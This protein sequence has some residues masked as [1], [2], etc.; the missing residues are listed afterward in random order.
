MTPQHADVDRVALYVARL[1]LEIKRGLRPPGHLQP[2]LGAGMLSVKWRR[3]RP[4][5]GGPYG[6]VTPADIGVPVVSAAGDRADASVPINL[7]GA[8]GWVALTVRLRR[9]KTRWR[10]TDLTMLLGGRGYVHTVRRERPVKDPLWPLHRR[11]GT[12]KKDR[13]LVA[14]VA[15][16]NRAD[17]GPWGPLLDQ[18]D[19]EIAQLQQRIDVLDRHERWDWAR[20]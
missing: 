17:A 15:V 14:M 11:L 7:G 19:R 5:G 18:L 8:H 4:V 9:V 1:T 16:V 12:A 10:I 20:R 3:A 2:L 13:E 6:P